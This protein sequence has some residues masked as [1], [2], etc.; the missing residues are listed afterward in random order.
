MMTLDNI[1][2]APAPGYGTPRKVYEAIAAITGELAKVG[3]SKAR[4][5]TQ[6]GY[7]FRGIDDVYGALSSLLS[8]YKLCVIPRVLNRIVTE[9]ESK[10]GGVLFYV[11]LDVEFDLVSA[12]DGSQHT[13]RCCG[14]AMD[15]GDKATNKAMSAAYKYFALQTFC[16]PTEG[17]ND[18]ENQTHEVA[19]R[20]ATYPYPMPA[21]KHDPAEAL[22]AALTPAEAKQVDSQ[23][24]EMKKLL[25]EDIVDELKCMKVADKHDALNALSQPLYTA[26]GKQLAAKDMRYWKVLVHKAKHLEDVEAGYRG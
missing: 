10:S 3:I 20:G 14:E 17:D 13:A 1:P 12:E 22:L 23:V 11:V 21:T 4:K 19:A 15:S 5:N 24:A 25:N 2:P 26:C 9:R 6:Q 16:I 18:T 7:A 8:Q